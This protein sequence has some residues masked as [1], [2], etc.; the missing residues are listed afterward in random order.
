MP[1]L[2]TKE[3]NQ[4]RL[5]DQGSQMKVLILANS[6]GLADEGARNVSRAILAGMR[7]R[8]KVLS[9]PAPA[10]VK[11]LAEIR[12][13]GPQVVHSLHGP[14]IRTFA[15]MSVLRLVVP[16]AALL[17]SLSQPGLDLKR[18]RPLLRGLR[19]VRLL[20]QDPVS[21][22]FFLRLGFSVQPLPNGVDTERFHPTEPILPKALQAR[23]T[24]DKPVLMHVGHLKL[25]RGLDVLAQLNG[26]HGW[27]VLVLGSLTS[28]TDPNIVEMLLA[29]GC[30][31]LR[32]FI[33]DLPGLYSAVNA[34]AFPVSDQM[35]AIDMPLS[36][37]EAMACNRPVIS[38]R[39]KALP[40]FLPQGD[41]LFYFASID[42][43][44]AS[45]DW[46]M[47]CNGVATREKVAPFSWKN[48][49]CQLEEIYIS[50]LRA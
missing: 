16:Q 36:V 40:R 37:L 1:G 8:C 24:P 48:I 27:Q 31:V 30:V 2:S 35:G 14:S 19:F 22:S 5:L 28:P 18:I 41:G 44:K 12:R 34:Y 13:F 6:G 39:F 9:M 38:T 7:Q 45:L 10:A 42:E 11:R 3:D 26:Y 50:C 4:V 21:E 33:K 32:E 47:D 43:A 46:I 20:S 29:A 17:A 49:L 15:L 23:L 25:H